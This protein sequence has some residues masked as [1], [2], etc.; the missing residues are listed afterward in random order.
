M[1][2]A[3]MEESLSVFRKLSDSNPMVAGKKFLP[4][5]SACLQASRS[6]GGALSLVSHY[7]YPWE[8]ETAQKIGRLPALVHSLND[9][10]QR[11]FEHMH[12]QA[13]LRVFQ[14]GSPGYDV[15]VVAIPEPGKYRIITKGDGYVY[16]TLQ[17]LQGKLLSCWKR[18]YAS[19]M[20]DPDLEGRVQKIDEECSE[21]PFWCS[22]DYEAATD[23]LKKDASLAVLAPLEA[24]LLSL[25]FDASVQ[26]RIRYPSGEIIDGIEGQLMGHP[27][28]FPSLCVINLAVYHHSINRWCYD[29]ALTGPKS[30][31]RRRRRLAWKMWKNVLVNGDDLLFKCDA[32]F[33]PFFLET[34][35][36]AGFKISIGKNYLSRDCGM[37]NSQLFKRSNGRMKRCGYFNQQLMR[38]FSIKE[39]SSLATPEQIARSLSEMVSRCP[40]TACSIP[41][42][43]ERWHS[44]W[45]GPFRPNWYLPVNLG[46]YGMDRALMPETCRFTR[47]QRI[48]AAR[49]VHDPRLSLYRLPGMDIPTAK[50]AHALA[51]WRMI[52]GDYV[53]RESESEDVSDQWL[54][55][56]AYASRAHQ[57]SKPIS[58][59]VFVS[60]FARQYRLK[61]MSL[62]GIE[63]Y[64]NARLFAFDLPPCP[65]LGDLR[66]R[67]PH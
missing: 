7:Q 37:I 19:T 24:P 60:K 2:K 32:S 16:T 56:L 53:P 52:T 66:L 43:M 61:P 58:D 22:A 30:E 62:E 44:D 48:M 47:S 15:S 36:M 51:N 11:Q 38:A 42:T 65:P 67:F 26:C 49:F 59:K 55:R 8:S 10:R 21:L 5:G 17:P 13:F 45:T 20:L 63:R 4:T 41:K 33:Y 12:D 14:P 46:G 9:W 29:A 3:I 57:G 39:G 50:L 64:W 23:L 27:L 28:S 54:A 34:A 35:A 40:W 31:L 25:G 18:C 6:K 1:K